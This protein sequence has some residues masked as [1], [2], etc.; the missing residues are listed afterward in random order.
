[1]AKV[2]VLPHAA[3]VPVPAGATLLDAALEAGLDFPHSCRSGNCGACKSRLLA[4]EVELMPHSEYALPAEERQAGLIL[5]CRAL[6]RAD[7]E[8]VPVDLE[9]P[10][11]APLCRI[12]L[13]VT[14][15]ES[16]ARRRWSGRSA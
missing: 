7:C 4:G 11:A 14:G 10:A 5:A 2:T 13:A 3:T 1:M 12:D 6:A 16:A 9:Q 15:S 8:I